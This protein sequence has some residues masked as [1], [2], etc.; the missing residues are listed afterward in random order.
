MR[1]QKRE[2]EHNRSS[3]FSVADQKEAFSLAALKKLK[4]ATPRISLLQPTYRAGDGA[5][6]GGLE[7][8]LHLEGESGL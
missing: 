2:G 7:G 1:G 8:R 5:V 6:D 4:F 3:A